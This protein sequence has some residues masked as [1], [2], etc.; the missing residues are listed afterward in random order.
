M[1]VLP[2]RHVSVSIDAA[3]AEV[4]AFAREPSNLP[5]WAAGLGSA[6]SEVN[7]EW[8]AGSPMGRV[9]VR[10]VERNALGV[11]DHDVTLESGATVANAMRVVPNGTGSEVLFTLLRQPG[12]TADAFEEDARA[13][14]RDLLA[15][16]RL[17]EGAAP[18]ASRG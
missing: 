3:P 17:L 6:I 18:A 9:K 10:F 5:R 16:K 11:L 14:E 4:Y 15:L 7:G 13:V 12:T 8:I 1:A 2:V